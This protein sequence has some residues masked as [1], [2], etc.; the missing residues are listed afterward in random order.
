MPIKALSY[1][2][3]GSHVYL[4]ENSLKSNQNEGPTRKQNFY[5]KSSSSS[6]SSS[7]IKNNNDLNQKSNTKLRNSDDFKNESSIE[8]K[9]VDLIRSDS[10][11]LDKILLIDKKNEN[12]DQKQKANIFYVE[13][14]KKQHHEKS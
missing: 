12:K 13:P 14:S 5:S 2:R 1:R 8:N 9:N 6:S 4:H 3:K 7:L 11:L 10:A